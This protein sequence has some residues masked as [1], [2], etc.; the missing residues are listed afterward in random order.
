MRAR[1][2]YIYIRGEFVNERKAVMRAIGAPC[3]R[4]AGGQHCNAGSSGGSA[5]RAICRQGR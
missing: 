4:V 1:A 5:V 2:G 3:E